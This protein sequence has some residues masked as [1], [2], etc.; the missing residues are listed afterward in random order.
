ME[1]VDPIRIFP[2]LTVFP[3][4]D[5]P[6]HYELKMI[7]TGGDQRYTF[8]SS[9]FD[10]VTVL[11][12]TEGILEITAGDKPRQGAVNG[13]M[14]RFPPNRDNA[15]IAI[16]PAASLSIPPHVA[17]AVVGTQLVIPVAMFGVSPTKGK[18]S[19]PFHSCQ[20]VPL[21]SKVSDSRSF[22][23]VSTQEVAPLSPDSKDGAQQTSLGC[24]GVAVEMRSPGFSSL[25]V[26]Y[27]PSTK[28]SLNAETTIAAFEPL[29]LLHKGD[30]ILAVGS[31][32]QLHF[33]GGPRPW[34]KNPSNHY[35]HVNGSSDALRV[36]RVQNAE[37]GDVHSFHVEILCSRVTLGNDEAAKEIP[38]FVDVRV[39]NYPSPSLPYPAEAELRIPIV[40]AAPADVTLIPLTTRPELEP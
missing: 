6:F 34:P 1:V 4:Q 26:A 31:S 8:G 32:Y 12:P 25:E 23:V 11:N 38:T 17:E 5:Q 18:E 21:A 2:R 3:C 30:V 29:Q 37:S 24:R 36:V 7:A 20:G 35:K 14:T 28:A 16:V 33:V 19:V 22:E 15:T 13:F 27:L 10:L 39:G 40:C 9:S